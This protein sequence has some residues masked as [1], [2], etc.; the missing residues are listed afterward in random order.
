MTINLPTPK[1][2]NK[3]Q[4][5]INVAMEEKKDDMTARVI[6]YPTVPNSASITEG[7]HSVSRS[8]TS[9]TQPTDVQSGGQ[10][11]RNIVKKDPNDF[12]KAFSKF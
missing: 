8:P 10:V 11:M 4:Q 12:E 3:Q 6:E 1:A 9:V 2:E 7:T 5:Q